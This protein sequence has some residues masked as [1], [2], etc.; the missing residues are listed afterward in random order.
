MKT[1]QDKYLVSSLVWCL[2]T[3]L[4]FAPFRAILKAPTFVGDIYFF[5]C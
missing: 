1:I 2:N 4:V 5:A 3:M